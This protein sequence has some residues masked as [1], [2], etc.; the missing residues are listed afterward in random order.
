MCGILCRGQ[1]R[2]RVPSIHPDGNY[3]CRTAFT[4]IELLVVIGIIGILAGLLLP[5]LGQARERG[6]SARCISNLR[7]IGLGMGM[8]CDDTGYYPPGHQ[9]GVTEWER[10]VAGYVGGS[11]DP[12]AGNTLTALFMCPSVKR[13]NSGLRINYSANPNICR[14][15]KSGTEPL[16]LS[17]ITTRPSEVITVADAI[18]YLGDGSS[19]AI[20]W[21]VLGSG[22]SEIYWNNGNPANANAPILVGTDNDQ[23]YATSDPNGSNFRYRHGGNSVNALFA[24]GHAA[25]LVKGQVRDRNLYTNY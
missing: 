5:A 1:G 15:I 19:H 4:L 17:A 13:P 6:R 23:V 7:Q 22:G 21:G 3:S 11:S 10:C 25:N 14:E 24:D 12:L 8:Y 2:Q 20:L 9:D 16:P 18:Q